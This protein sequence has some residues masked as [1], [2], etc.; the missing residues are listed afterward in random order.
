MNTVDVGV[1]V[2][3]A[4][5]FLNEKYGSASARLNK[6]MARQRIKSKNNRFGRD[7]LM[8]R[9]CD[10]ANRCTAENEMRFCCRRVKRWIRMG[11]L[12]P[13]IPN[14]NRGDE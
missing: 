3:K 6:A 8:D 14:K 5:E 9:F 1:A 11:T 2:R 12:I 4:S 10:C 7:F 13:N